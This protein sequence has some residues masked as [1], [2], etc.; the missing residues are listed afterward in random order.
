MLNVIG[1]SFSLY[2]IDWPSDEYNKTV[3]S[4]FLFCKTSI[5]FRWHDMKSSHL[6]P[7]TCHFTGIYSLT[8][9]TISDYVGETLMEK[10]KREKAGPSNQK[11]VRKKQ[12][13]RFVFILS[14]IHMCVESMTYIPLKKTIVALTQFVKS[15]TKHVATALV[16]SCIMSLSEIHHSCLDANITHN[17]SRNLTCDSKIWCQPLWLSTCHGKSSDPAEEL[18][19]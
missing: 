2:D 9:C 3:S 10:T 5:L 13:L 14:V 18:N 12:L 16:F 8:Q 17:Q 7:V 15:P 1:I 11:I 4:F 6:R 19:A